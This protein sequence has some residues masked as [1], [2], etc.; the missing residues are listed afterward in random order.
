MAHHRGIRRI[1]VGLGS[2]AALVGA[3]LL[4]MA[5]SANECHFDPPVTVTYDVV[6]TCDGGH[7]GRVTLTS[8]TYVP[9]YDPTVQI[10]S[11]DITFNSV[12]L[13]GDCMNGSASLTNIDFVLPAAGVAGGETT[14]SISLPSGLGSPVDCSAGS[15]TIQITPVQ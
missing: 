8:A 14:C 3:V 5:D 9:D 2:L 12:A 13:R 7:A 10:V 4:L 6:T 11:G 1:A 15:C